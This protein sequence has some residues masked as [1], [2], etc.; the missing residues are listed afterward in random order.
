MRDPAAAYTVRGREKALD[1][2]TE[3]YVA[4]LLVTLETKP[5]RY[6]EDDLRCVAERAVCGAAEAYN[7]HSTRIVSVALTTIEEVVS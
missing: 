4:T 2:D 3:T 7:L 6:T 1:G 5:S